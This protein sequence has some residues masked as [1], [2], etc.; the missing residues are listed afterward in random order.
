MLH[1][2]EV[3]DALHQFAG[4]L[5]RAVSAAVVDQDDL[6]IYPQLL[7]HAGDPLHGTFDVCLFVVGGKNHRQR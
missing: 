2:P 4:N 7:S 3:G 5:T 6:V 1:Q